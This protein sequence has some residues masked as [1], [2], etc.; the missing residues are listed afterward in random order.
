MAA[1]LHSV[2]SGAH[3]NA[4]VNVADPSILLS[5]RNHMTTSRQ[6]LLRVES[7]GKILLMKYTQKDAN[8]CKNLYSFKRDIQG[9]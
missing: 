9:N 5:A 7:N 4:V 3:L 1:I 6:L 8:Y 2:Q